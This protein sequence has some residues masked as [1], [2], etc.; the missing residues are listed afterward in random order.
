MA[1]RII[2]QRRFSKLVSST[3]VLSQPPGALTRLSNLLYTQ[4]GSLQICDGSANVASVSGA[5][6]RIQALASFANL[7]PGQFPYY[8]ALALNPSAQLS[9][10]TGFA[11]SPVIGTGTNNPAGFPEFGIVATLS[12]G[13]SDIGPTFIS[14]HSVVPFDGVDFSWTAVPGATGYKIY[15]IDASAFPFVNGWLLA[16]VGA[17]TAYSYTGVLN[18]GS[19]VPLPYGNTSY[20]L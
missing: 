13:H 14:F 7:I 2:S 4:R 17:V 9:P 16:T 18:S 6:T 8:S 20:L 3:G 11:A 10:V 19:E 15:F 12:G 1:A 5:Y